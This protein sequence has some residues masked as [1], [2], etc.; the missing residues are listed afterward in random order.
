MPSTAT[1]PAGDATIP[2]DSIPSAFPS[3]AAFQQWR[4]DLLQRIETHLPG[5]YRLV[6][7]VSVL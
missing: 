1:D 4:V 5:A 3:L 6:I 7:D 2:N